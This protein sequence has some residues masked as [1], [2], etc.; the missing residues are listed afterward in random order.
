MRMTLYAA[1]TAACVA[2]GPVQ[3]LEASDTMAAWKTAP[4][5][6]RTSLVTDMLKRDGQ[7]GS[8][9]PVMNCLDAAA[10]VSGHADLSIRQIVEAC[11]KNEGDPV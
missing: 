11:A 4:A 5:D 2:C 10:C 1:A 7:K 8:T 6:A 3:A 9:L